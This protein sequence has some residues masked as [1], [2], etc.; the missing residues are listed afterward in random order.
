MMRRTALVTAALGA[1]ALTTAAQAA[2]VKLLA[3]GAVASGLA[4]AIDL[5]RA[6]SGHTVVVAYST[7]PEVA[8]RIGAGEQGFDVVA[9]PEPVLAALNA[10]GRLKA[11][12]VRLG[13]VGIAAAIKPGTPRPD[14]TNAD[15]FNAYLLAAKT[16]VISRGST[17]VHLEEQFKRSSLTPGIEPRLERGRNGAAVVERLL[18]GNGAEIGLS[19]QTELAGGV[20][21]G[22]IVVGLLPAPLQNYT[23]YAAAAFPQALARPE[24]E[25]FMALLKSPASAALMASSGIE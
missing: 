22:L 23:T 21:R 13:K 16:V 4:K 6:Q 14:L 9:A 25:G 11:T 5:Y 20:D 19:G 18:A 24:V 8:Q 10:S 17:G 3:T 7:G 15:K 1:L 2:E 12:S